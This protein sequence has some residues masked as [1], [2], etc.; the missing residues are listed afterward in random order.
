[1]RNLLRRGVKKM[2]LLPLRIDLNSEV[3]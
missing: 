1:M 3:A 2:I